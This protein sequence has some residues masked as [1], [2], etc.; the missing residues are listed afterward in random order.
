MTA[1]HTTED[2]DVVPFTVTIVG[3]VENGVLGAIQVTSDNLAN[4]TA[5]RA[6]LEAAFEA[7][8]EVPQ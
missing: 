4:L 8:T 7:S 2:T 6:V 5:V 1:P 3:V